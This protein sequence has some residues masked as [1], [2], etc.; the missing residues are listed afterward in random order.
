MP[1]VLTAERRKAIIDEA[2]SKQQPDGGFSLSEFVGGWKRKDNTPLD[3]RADGYATGLVTFALEQNGV[4]RSDPRLKRA[5]VW[6]G[7]NQQPVQLARVVAQQATRPYD[8]RGA[9]HGRR[10]D[11]FCG[12]S[13]DRL[14]LRGF[15]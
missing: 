5:L 7:A 4:F 14:E 1:G 15:A 13:V 3:A 10:G 12:V 9:L 8:R 2:L 6:L 11:G